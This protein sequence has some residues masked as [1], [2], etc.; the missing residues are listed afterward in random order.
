MPGRPT[1]GRIA[2]LLGWAIL[3]LAPAVPAAPDERGLIGRQITDFTLKEFRGKAYSLADYDNKQAVVVY[4]MGT[5]CPLAKLY[6]PRVQQLAQQFAPQGVAFLGVNSNVQ[7]SITELAALQMHRVLFSWQ[8][9][10]LAVGARCRVW[11]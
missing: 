10:S 4:F 11:S 7:D 2:I 1:A 9:F 6:G 8:S 3:G 5:E